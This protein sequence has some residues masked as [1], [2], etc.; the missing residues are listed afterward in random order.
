VGN[1]EHLVIH[2]VGENSLRMRRFCNVDALGS[3]SPISI[4]SAL[5]RVGYF[6]A[7]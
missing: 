4:A 6:V 5:H 2:V 7:D 3:E 1:V